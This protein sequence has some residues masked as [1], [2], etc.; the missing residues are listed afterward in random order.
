MYNIDTSRKIGLKIFL[1]SANCRISLRVYCYYNYNYDNYITNIKTQSFAYTYRTKSSMNIAE[2]QKSARAKVFLCCR[3]KLYC[4]YF[5]LSG[6]LSEKLLFEGIRLTSGRVI[7][8]L[9]KRQKLKKICCFSTERVYIYI[10]IYIFIY[11]LLCETFA[12]KICLAKA[13]CPENNM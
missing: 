7:R 8:K 9:P 4:L 12:A 13:I 1:A 11:E 10:Y 2:I 3:Y 5:C 6:E